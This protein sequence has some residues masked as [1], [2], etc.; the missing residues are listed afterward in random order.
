MDT[1]GLSIEDITSLI[2]ALKQELTK[3]QEEGVRLNTARF[4][5]DGCPED[6]AQYRAGVIGIQSVDTSV[7]AG[8]IIANNRRILLDLQKAGLLTS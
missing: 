6:E 7:F 4:I 3:N 8:I 1:I 5:R 2:V